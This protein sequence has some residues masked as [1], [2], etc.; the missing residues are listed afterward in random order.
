MVVNMDFSSFN[1]N[2]GSDFHSGFCTILISSDDKG[3]TGGALVFDGIKVR[4][5]AIPGD[6]VFFSYCPHSQIRLIFIYKPQI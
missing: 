6:I 3:F 1:H 5:A 4:V 2:D